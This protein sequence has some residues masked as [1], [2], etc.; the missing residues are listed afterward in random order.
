MNRRNIFGSK[1][2]SE[3]GGDGM[4]KHEK[5]SVVL[6]RVVQTAPHSYRNFDVNVSG[7]IKVRATRIEWLKSNS[8]ASR[9][10]PAPCGCGMML[11]TPQFYLPQHSPSFFWCWQ[12]WLNELA[13]GPLAECR[14][15]AHFLW[16]WRW[17]SGSEH[18]LC[19]FFNK[20]KINALVYYAKNTFHTSGN[21]PL[22]R[23]TAAT[24]DSESHNTTTKSSQSR[25]HRMRFSILR[26]RNGVQHNAGGLRCFEV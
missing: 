4:R 5:Q 11:W 24:A 16:Q 19:C 25:S 26:K 23:F 17:A 21:W 22:H 14:N 2:L 9:D 20:P 15:S 6:E 10:P 13:E 1:F 12:L 8:A 3:C 7:T 18:E